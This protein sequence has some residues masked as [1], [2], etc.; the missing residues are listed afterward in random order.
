VGNVIL[1]DERSPKSRLLRRLFSRREPARI[2]LSPL[3]VLLYLES[4]Q[5][6]ARVSTPKR[7][8]LEIGIVGYD[9]IKN[10]YLWLLEHGYIAPAPDIPIIAPAEILDPREFVVTP[11]G[12][13]ALEPYLATFSMAEVAS[14]AAVTLGL[15]FIL[16]L[17]Y[18]LFQLYPSYLGL[19]I[20][21][22]TVISAVFATMGILTLKEGRQRYKE[23][24]ASLIESVKDR[25]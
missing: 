23:R 7:L 17:S 18:L 21:L 24:V 10:S 1:D 6:Q 16:G 5:N 12:K 11:L 9:V 13:K 4:H 2:R 3:K 19:L 22:D 15:G 8:G 14:V 25:G 20:L